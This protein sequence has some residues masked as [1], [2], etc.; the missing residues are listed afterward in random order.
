MAPDELPPFLPWQEWIALRPAG[1][2][3]F[4]WRGVRSSLQRLA[5]R[6]TWQWVAAVLLLPVG[7]AW[8][9]GTTLR[10]LVIYRTGCAPHRGNAGTSEYLRHRFS[11]S[12]RL[13][14]WREQ[15]VVASVLRWLGPVSTILDVPSGYGRLT[16]VLAAVAPR[17]VVSADI[18]A[19]RLRAV[20]DLA[21]AGRQPVVRVDLL[22]GTPF[23]TQAFDLVLNMR[24]LHHVHAIDGQ[25]RV[26]RELTRVS[27]HY[28]VVSYYRNTN[29]HAVV[30]RLQSVTRGNRRR[31]PAMMARYQFEHL[32]RGTGWR[33]VFDQAL[34]PG[35]HAQRV[36][37][38]ER[39]GPEVM[40]VT[41]VG[42]RSG[43]RFRAAG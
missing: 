25:R 26:L 1:K 3:A 11:G 38:L 9:L 12:Q 31:G 15:R 23:P 37:V 28:V 17:V 30:R 35:L 24:F 32:M 10:D 33:I 5:A 34:L 43:R 16:P 4:A 2:L 20:R 39:V 41:P 6:G 42:A 27:R 36:A 13:V 29:L 19:G 22:R 8:A 14:D 18:H 40:Q 7:A 21:L